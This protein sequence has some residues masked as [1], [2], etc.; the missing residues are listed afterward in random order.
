MILHPKR[1]HFGYFQLQ[2]SASFSLLKGRSQHVLVFMSK[3][4]L[5]KLQSPTGLAVIPWLIPLHVGLLLSKLLCQFI[6]KLGLILSFLLMALLLLVTVNAPLIH[7]HREKCKHW[8]ICSVCFSM[9]H[10]CE[11]VCVTIR[12]FYF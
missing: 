6:L 1:K 11:V 5:Q 3:F 2:D 8:R 7:S 9:T 4:P 10:R 12:F